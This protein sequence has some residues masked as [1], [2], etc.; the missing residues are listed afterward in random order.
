MTNPLIALVF[1][2][3]FGV[4]HAAEVRPA[5]AEVR[6]AVAPVAVAAKLPP[7]QPSEAARVAARKP[8]KAATVRGAGSK[9]TEAE[10]R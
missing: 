3:A 1:A 7:P 8:G 10:M 4:A 9:A 6:P 2:A 5:N